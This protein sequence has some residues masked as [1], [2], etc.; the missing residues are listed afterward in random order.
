MKHHHA[1]GW[2]FGLNALFAVLELVGGFLTGSIAILSD[3]FH[4]FGDSLSIGLA[5]GL[6]RISRKPADATHTY[7]YRR[8][9]VLGSLITTLILVI[10]S[11]VVIVHAVER[12]YH[13]VEVAHD[14]MLVIAVI[15]AAVNILA[16]FFTA[17]GDSL[18]QKAVY[19][20]M[21]EDVLGWIA[22]IIGALVIKF[23]GI[24]WIDPVLSIGVA[25]VIGIQAVRHGWASM[26][27]F[28]E[29]TPPDLDV[30]ELTA[31]L[32]ALDGVENI[33]HLH[34]WSLDGG[35]HMATLHAV[36]RGDA[37]AVKNAL[38][39]ELA[40]HGIS[41]ATIETETTEDI[42]TDQ[43]CRLDKLAVSAH[44]HAHHHHHH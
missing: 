12:L 43:H 3:A 5:Y 37:A 39:G 25:A 10:G 11:V 35:A 2:A 1:I 27:V 36:C 32:S 13:P 23:T 38:K 18:N 31:H 28:L 26:A 21:M 9:S 20:H 40:E 42:C 44:S 16:A 29:Q 34:I 17:G 8:Y 14:G 24:L 15:G 4:D 22:V 6:E 33:H 7:G 30:E 41:H 19:L